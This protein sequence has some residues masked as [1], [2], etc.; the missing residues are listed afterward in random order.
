MSI[1]RN[2][3][4]LGVGRVFT[5]IVRLPRQQA[6]G[7]FLF[8]CEIGLLDKSFTGLKESLAAGH[9]PA[10]HATLTDGLVA[11]YF[12]DGDASDATGNGNDGTVNG[13]AP[14]S[15]RNGVANAAFSFDG[16]NDSI[17]IG[18]GVKPAI[19]L[20]VNLWFNSRTI[21]LYPLFRN[22]QVDGGSF[23]HGAFMGTSDNKLFMQIFSGFSVP[24]T[25]KGVITVD[26]VIVADEWNMFTAVFGAID[27]LSIYLNGV[28]QNVTPTTG[29]G[30]AFTYS[31]A[32]GAIGAVNDTANNAVVF[33]SI[34][35]DGFIDDICVYDR[36]LSGDEVRQLFSGSCAAPVSSAPEPGTF[37]LL[38]ASLL[39]SVF[40]GRRMVR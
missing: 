3:R 36:A 19:P 37:T 25:R 14:A 31:N 30:N 38:I 18:N 9:L 1:V 5:P 6:A 24:S 20:T 39:G 16:I 7:R 26:D 23:R 34:S 2:T 35:F 11:A 32:N 29:T 10:A 28:E 27:D 12:F 33:S 40:V 4:D 8:H 17:D 21:G 13:A 15:D 22:D